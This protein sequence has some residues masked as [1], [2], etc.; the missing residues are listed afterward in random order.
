M[1]RRTILLSLLL[2]A[3]GDALIVHAQNK[4]P[5]RPVK[6][7]VP[8][9]PGALTD[10]LARLLASKLQ[11]KW[12]QPVVV[13][14]RVGASGNIGTEFVYRSP[15]DGHTLLFTPQSTLVLSKLMNPLVG[16]DPE[17]FSPIAMVTRSTVLLLVNAK[18]PIQNVEQ[19]IAYA[20]N[21]PGKL[22]FASTGIGSTAQLSNDLFLYLSKTKGVNIPYQG[23]APAANALLAGD[24]DV[25]FDA[26]GNSLPHIRAGKLRALA[27]AG[28]M[29]NP[30]LPDVPTVSESL[31]GFASPLWTGLV[32]PPKTPQIIIDQ[33]S[34]DVAQALRHPDF[35]TRIASTPGLD[36]VGSTPDEMQRAMKDERERWS[37]IIKMTGSRGE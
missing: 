8:F 14:N 5:T 3:W 13:E 36:S 26:M 27:V 17:S 1:K 11:E 10:S 32:A 18:S 30:A 35:L 31:P 23:I 37:Q 33:I 22:N 7:V 15:A 9:P 16:F 6:V 21:N 24:V 28:V 12:Q 2:M 19:L 29:R 34:A 25:L 20:T 4:F